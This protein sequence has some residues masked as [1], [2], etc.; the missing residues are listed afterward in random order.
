MSLGLVANRKRSI[1]NGNEYNKYFDLTEVQGN[2]VELMPDGSVYDTLRHMQKIVRAT[3]HQTKRIAPK[4]KGSTR[5]ATARNIYNFLYNHVQYRKDNPLREQLRTPARTWKD[6]A[7]GVDCDCYAIFISSVLTNLQIPHAFRIAGYKGDF[8]HVYV[9]VPKSGSAF[10]SYYTIDPVVDRF[11]YETPFSKKHDHAMQKVT[12]LNGVEEC[13]VLP[14]ADRLKRYVYTDQVVDFGL[15][16]TEQFLQQNGFSFEKVTD[17]ATNG[18][19]FAVLTKSGLVQVPTIISPDQAKQL[20]SV[21]PG[22]APEQPCSCQ[23]PAQKKFNWWWLA[24]AGGALVLLTGSD[25]EQVSPG[26]S[27]VPKKKKGKL[28]T[29]HI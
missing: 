7:A 27:G 3:L 10:G 14:I 4:L 23:D 5:E 11:N 12:M 6:R 20:L 9:I 2:E 21:G 25:Q 24:I 13:P 28:T 8:Q 22:A 17:P 19:A 26:L 18:S 29:V 1:R 16:P 15:V